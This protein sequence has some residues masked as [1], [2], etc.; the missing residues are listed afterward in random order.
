MCLAVVRLAVVVRDDRRGGSYW[1]FASAAEEI[2][3]SMNLGCLQVCFDVVF[4][5]L[6]RSS[7]L[8]IPF[9]L[10]L[11][12]LGSSWIWVL[13]SVPRGAWQSFVFVPNITCSV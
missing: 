12:S 6:G 3:V 7:L 13:S 5:S 10:G 8:P 9:L 1:L 4:T 11:I 2:V